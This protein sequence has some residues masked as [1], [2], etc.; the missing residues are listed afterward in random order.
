VDG[1]S[2]PR[3]S[4]RLHVVLARDALLGV[5]FRRGPSK[6]V[7]TILWDRKTDKFSVGQWLKGRIYERRS[8]ISQ[9]GKYL[10][11]FAQK[12]SW[13][14]EAKGSWT[15]ISKAPYLKAVAIFPKGDC[16]NGGGLFTNANRYWLNDGC[17][18]TVLRDTTLVRRDLKFKPATN[19]GGEC[20]S[21][22]YP[23]LLRDGWQHVEHIRHAQWNDLDYFEKTL[24]HGWVVRK[25]AHAEIGAPPGKG[26]Y[27]DEHE[28]IHSA[29]SQCVSYADWE[30][31]EVDRNRLVWAQAGKLFAG[32]IAKQ[33]LVN[34]VQLFD[35]NDMQFE[36]LEAPY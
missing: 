10:I 23:R 21:V 28:L 35:F 4:A 16:W 14:S 32:K 29:S 1:Y 30:W 25:I 36:P 20:L 22:Y 6:Q 13:S 3:F 2:M 7:C 27:W 5:V 24:P 18:H 34:E 31:A 15:A 19:N 11:Y 9:D 8:D 26:C 17:G 33:G 12:G